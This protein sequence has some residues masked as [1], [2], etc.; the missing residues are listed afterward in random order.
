MTY[1]RFAPWTLRDLAGCDVDNRSTDRRPAAKWT[2]AVDIVEEDSGFRLRADIPGVDPADVEVNLTDEI[3]SIS[4]QRGPDA[5]DDAVTRRRVE[6]SSGC[7]SRRFK[8]P[9]TIDADGITARC[10]NGILEVVIPKAPETP[11]RRISVKAA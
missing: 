10:N 4:G 11:A 7:F 3:L 5:V 9:D 1:S 8:I 2:P 6:R